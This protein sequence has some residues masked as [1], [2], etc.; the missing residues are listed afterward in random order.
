MSGP[1]RGCLRNAA[2]GCGLAVVFAVAIPVILAIM[3]MGPLSTAVADRQAGEAR[4]G[5]QEQFVPPVTG[6]PTAERVEAFLAVR[7][8]LAPTCADFWRTED[9]VRELE[10]LDEHGEASKLEALGRALTTT[11][12]MMAMGPLIGEFYETR[13][14][15]LLDAGMGLGEYTYLYVLAYRKQILNPDR[16]LQLFGPEV[17]NPRVQAALRSMLEHQLVAA[18]ETGADR[19]IEVALEHEIQA[20]TTDPKRIPWQDGMPA[21]LTDDLAPY[22]ERLDDAFCGASAPLELLINEKRFLAIESK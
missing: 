7:Q 1:Q 6:V 9:A 20:M 22:R 19:E 16:E 3:I 8:E 4:F 17:V 12:R 10:A 18:T 15:A 2:I 5:A 13:N 11:R 21:A 14:R